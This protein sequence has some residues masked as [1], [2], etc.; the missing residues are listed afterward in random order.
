M[1]SESS[2]NKFK[3]QYCTMLGRGVI[4]HKLRLLEW[5]KNERWETGF[6]CFLFLFSKEGTV[7]KGRK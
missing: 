3:I 2:V 1:S 6:L 7:V 4:G 5:D